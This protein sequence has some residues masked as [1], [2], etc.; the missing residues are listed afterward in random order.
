MIWLR[1][2]ILINH[3]LGILSLRFHNNEFYAVVGWLDKNGEKC[4]DTVQLDD[5]FFEEQC[6]PGFKEHIMEQSSMKGYVPL[7]QTDKI[8]ANPQQVVR[9]KFVRQTPHNPAH[10][11]GQKQDSSTITL[12]EDYVNKNFPSIMISEAHKR[13]TNKGNKF[14]SVPPGES[15]KKNPIVDEVVKKL[16]PTKYQD[17][18]DDKCLLIGFASALHYLGDTK[19]AEI[20][21]NHANTH[22][23]LDVWKEFSELTDK[24]FPNLN[25]SSVKE[26]EI[27][28]FIMDCKHH[29]IAVVNVVDSFD[30]IAHAFTVTKNL[31]FDSNETTSL[32]CS[33]MYFDR[34][35]SS[36]NNKC[37]ATKV[38]RAIY[39]DKKK[40][41]SLS[42]QYKVLS[43]L[44]QYFGRIERQDCIDHLQNIQNNMNPLSPS[45]NEFPQKILKSL[46]HT[47]L[48]T[49]NVKPQQMN[50]VKGTSNIL[51]ILNI[52]KHFST[53]TLG[54][55]VVGYSDGKRGPIVFVFDYVHLYLN[56]KYIDQKH[57]YDYFKLNIGLIKHACIIKRNKKQKK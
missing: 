34:C 42:L 9:L 41:V 8:G 15:M 45:I 30:G 14:V 5:G 44:I 7:M 23:T 6:K 36:K 18:D 56:G 37:T 52:F 33:T 27:G 21:W 35:V 47:C 38:Y 29:Y 49:T 54:E 1:N 13:S 2:I 24:M 20:I 3:A 16:P 53:W 4:Y 11:V 25:K 32:P 43:H 28:Q 31:I 10:W 55:I 48:Q 46:V 17:N 40:D 22:K 26:M 50:I 51:T 12:E 19:N 39:F 57:R